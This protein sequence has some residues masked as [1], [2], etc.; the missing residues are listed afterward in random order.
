MGCDVHMF[1]ERKNSESNQWEMVRD[2]FFYDYSLEKAEEY[3]EHNLGL[4][5]EE[6]NRM[7]KKYF[8]GGQPSNKIEE[9]VFN[10]FL[11]D[12][13]SNDSEEIYKYGNKLSDPRSDQPYHGRNYGLFG[14]LAGVRDCSRDMI[15]GGLRGLPDDVSEEILGLS[16]DWDGDGHSH[17]YLYLNEILDS[18]YYRMS[19]EE[20]EENGFT[21]FFR[22]VVNDLLEI[23]N[24]DNLRLVFWFDN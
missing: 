21:Y 20:L 19:D 1:V 6:S 10:K 3:M 12:L 2:E 5:K 8:K 7:I 23:G 15:T 16:N 9:F 17:N 24:P 4:T 13:F 11:V 18:H 14:V 22:T